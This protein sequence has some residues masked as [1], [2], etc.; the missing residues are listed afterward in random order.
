MI[1]KIRELMQ[2][3]EDI[4]QVKTS[5]NEHQ[6]SVNSMQT[7]LNNLKQT[8][9][10]TQEVQSSFLKSFQD[11]ISIIQDSKEALQKEIYDFKLLKTRTQDLI[12]KKLE[13][14]ISKEMTTHFE[15]LK[16]DATQYNELKKDVISISSTTKRLTD[17]IDK[18]INISSEIKKGDFELT[19][20]ANKL[21]VMDREKLELM[22]KIDTLERL[23]SKIRR[24]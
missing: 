21:L 13:E 5:L 6:K 22:R 8:F 7:D 11:N 4:D 15:R 3:K 17:E 14:E 19:Q 2:V 20:F 12:M 10:D 18:F 1:A 24:K 9:L 23:I 16:T